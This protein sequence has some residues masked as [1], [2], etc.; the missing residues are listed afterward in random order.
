MK[1]ESFLVNITSENPEKM[2]AFYRDVLELAPN[3]Q[4]G[5][6]AFN[7]SDSTVLH[8][9]GHSET[10]GRTQEPQRVLFDFFVEDVEAEQQQL[11]AKGVEF[12]RELGLEWWG[13]IISTF[14]DPDGNYLQIIQFDPSK[15]T[16]NPDGANAQ[17]ANA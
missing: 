3:E 17:T 10:H 5:E 16:A 1:I 14:T 2:A 7:L 12:V 15:A 9:D 13:G 8:I 6:G 4:V 11:K